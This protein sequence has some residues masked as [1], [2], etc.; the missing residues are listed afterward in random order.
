MLKET[1][2]KVNK[3]L[4]KQIKSDLDAIIMF[5]KSMHEVLNDKRLNPELKSKLKKGAG[6]MGG[7]ENN[8]KRIRRELLELMRNKDAK[9]KE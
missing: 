6:L 3:K 5:E 8:T 2:F 7:A 9:I 4:L 1:Y